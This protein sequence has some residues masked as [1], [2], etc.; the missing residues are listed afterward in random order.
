MN[1]K[2]VKP[3][4]LKKLRRAYAG[5]YFVLTC[6]FCVLFFIIIPAAIYTL[7]FIPI[8]NLDDNRTL[9]EEV[10]DSVKSMYEY[11]KGV[12]TP[13]PYSSHWYEWPLMLRPIY[14]HAGPLLPEG[15]GSSIA[16]F[17]NPMVWWT[18]FIAFFVMI[19]LLLA[20]KIKKNLGPAESRIGWFPIVGYLSLYLPWV[21]AP[22]K[23][24]FIYHY[25]SCV[26]FLILMIAMVMRYLEGIKRVGR[27]A[28]YILMSLVLVLFILYYPVLSGL[29][30]PRWYLNA[31]R[32]LPG[33]AW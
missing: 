19:W 2:Q 14:Y 7:S 4:S 13:H 23:L 5:K 1:Q 25:F 11:H 20:G 8:Q 21:I 24:T 27:R 31:L 22:R 15:M 9:V 12:N 18:G 30:V 32:I 26:P 28:S 17:G 33:W 6:L 16:S 3:G 29:V 10:I